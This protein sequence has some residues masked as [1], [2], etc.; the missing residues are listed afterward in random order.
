RAG[1][2]MGR[3]GMADGA[4]AVVSRGRGFQRAM[5][6]VTGGAGDSRVGDVVAPAVGQPVW[7]EA[8]VE[9]AARA[10]HRDLRPGAM[11]PAAALRHPLRGRV[12]E[13]S[14]FGSGS[15]TRAHR[16]YVLFRRTVTGVA[17]D[18]GNEGFNVQ[19]ACRDAAGGVTPEA[20]GLIAGPH[21]PPGRL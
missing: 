5:R 19:P 3:R 12:G 6:I 14:H 8:N 4:L 13:L 15:I 21:S 9:H 16:G 10:A 7:L 18:A 1:L 11:A 20:I 17:A 2:C